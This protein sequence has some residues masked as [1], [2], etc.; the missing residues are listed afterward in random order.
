MV[1]LVYNCLLSEI[2][3]RII[4]VIHYHAHHPKACILSRVADGNPLAPVEPV[5]EEGL[6]AELDVGFSGP[7]AAVFEDPGF[8]QVEGKHRMHNPTLMF[9]KT[10]IPLAIEMLH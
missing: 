2:V 8:A 5:S 4:H 6:S 9:Y 3:F 1:L 10:F 7:S